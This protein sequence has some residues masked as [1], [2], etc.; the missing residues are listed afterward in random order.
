MLSLIVAMDQNQLIGQNNTLPWHLPADL[1]FFKKMTTGHTII[2]GRK[3]FESIG[4]PLPN[5]RNIVLTRNKD[6]TSSAD[7][8]IF[9]SLTEVM[10]AIQK[11]EK[12]YII[13]GANLYAQAISVVDEMLITK[14][15]HVFHGDA[16]FP[17][18]HEDAWDIEV[19]EK[20]RVDEKNVYNHT[21]LR[22]TR[23]TKE[24]LQ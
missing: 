19:L 2:M 20:G 13:G 23:K 3:T 1:K 8:E 4:K 12:A 15:D 9:S 7:I 6:W 17:K 5:R 21:Y 18:F 16:Y 22:Y 10:Q 11:E 14:I 24:V